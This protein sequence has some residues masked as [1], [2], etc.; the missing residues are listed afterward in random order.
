MRFLLKQPSLFWENTIIVIQKIVAGRVK[1]WDDVESILIEQKNKL[2]QNYIEDWLKQ[3]A[4]ILE[5][6]ELFNKYK[7]LLQKIKALC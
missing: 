1:D 6:Q 7:S 5:K 2:D 4:D 3:F